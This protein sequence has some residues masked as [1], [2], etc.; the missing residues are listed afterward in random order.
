M[1]CKACASWK[2]A[3]EPTPVSTQTWPKGIT[4]TRAAAAQVQNAPRVRRSIHELQADYDAGN[5]KPLEDLVRAWKGI[6]EL[7]SIDG[8]S[9]CCLAGLHGAPFIYRPEVDALPDSSTFT[10][11]GGWC[12]HANVL[13]PTW[14]RCYVLV[15]ERALQS[16]VPDVMMPYWDEASEESSKEG[17]PRIF[18]QREFLLD[19]QMVRNPLRSFT[20]PEAVPDAEQGEDM[21]K[22]AGYTTVRY[23]YSG[24]VGTEERRQFSDA[25]NAQFDGQ[26]TDA[27]LNEN[28]RHWL[29]GPDIPVWGNSPWGWLD[30]DGAAAK[31]RMCLEAPNY[32]VFSNTTSATQYNSMNPDK[33]VKSLEEPHNAMHLAV[34]GFTLHDGTFGAG[35]IEGANGDIAENNVASFDPLFWFHHCFVDRM[36]WLWQQRH[37]QTE[38]FEIIA[39][40]GGTNTYA[41]DGPTPGMKPGE[42]LNM[43]TPLYP[44]SKDLY[45][46]PYTSKDV[47]NIEKLGYTYA[48]GSFSV[49]EVT[50]E[51]L[52]EEPALGVA[53]AAEDPTV[54]DPLQIILG[55]E[56]ADRSVPR[57]KEKF[58]VVRGIDRSLFEGS[59]IIHA[60]AYF[61][62]DH[63]ETREIPLGCFPVLS[64]YNVKNCANCLNHLEVVAQFRIPPFSKEDLEHISF[65]VEIQ[66][67]MH[68]GLPEGLK[69][70]CTVDGEPVRL[71]KEQQQ[72]Q[73]RRRNRDILAD[74][75]GMDAVAG[76]SPM[77][78]TI[79]S[80][81]VGGGLS[82]RDLPGE[83]CMIA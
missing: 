18:L 45:G 31:F 81:I 37:G 1:A 35:V 68:H 13:F 17:I 74:D 29:N 2:G 73:P 60:C 48:A 27:L 22:P 56:I 50:Q 19:G 78:A 26:D 70:K 46:A 40:Y 75:V 36:F 16:L 11:W 43:D 53:T 83:C 64:R 7:P 76:S 51:A 9:F 32:T 12:H 49:P 33:A 28:V 72:Q 80:P 38:D 44:F 57:N 82:T 23:P 20:L 14:H 15:L 54:E 6:Q 71:K 69:W 10:Y 34:G 65:R 67:R 5:T 47:V 3:A 21:Q 8:R 30:S 58:L 42:E 55:R 4:R 79:R 52:N 61:E 62:D 66:H 77:S 41:G 39:G 63:G 25:H 59:F 24:L